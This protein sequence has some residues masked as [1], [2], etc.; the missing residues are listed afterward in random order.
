MGNSQGDGA[1]GEAGGAKKMPC[2]MATVVKT[3]GSA[4]RRPG[5]RMFLYADGRR[6]GSISGGCLEAD[7]AERALKT[8]ATGK[9]VYM[10]Y[11]TNAEGG[12]VFFETGCNGAIGILIEPL[13]NPNAACY[14]EWMAQCH[15]QRRSAILATVYRASDNCGVALGSRFLLHESGEIETD[16]SQPALRGALLVESQSLLDALK[17]GNRT[18]ALREGKVEVLLEKLR[19]PIQIL[20]CGAGQDAIP[21]AQCAAQ[22]GW[23]ALIADHRDAFLAPERFPFARSPPRH[24]PGKSAPRILRRI[25]EP[26]P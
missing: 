5:A 25:P 3:V 1:V 16:I 24:A 8:L 9:P 6:E 13:D 14:L 18:M 23:E 17:A 7:V 2:A 19:P 20:I 26:S 12:D 11:D 22:L 4:Y 10:M 21:L 15:R